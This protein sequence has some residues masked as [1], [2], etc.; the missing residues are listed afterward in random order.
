MLKRTCTIAVFNI[1]KN[2]KKLFFLEDCSPFSA[3]HLEIQTYHLHLTLSMLYV[4]RVPGS[5]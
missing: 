3:V 1:S 2:Y 5:H 4:Q